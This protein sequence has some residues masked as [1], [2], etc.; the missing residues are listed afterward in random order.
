VRAWLFG[1]QEYE[2]SALRWL[3]IP[4][5]R[6]GLLM[7]VTPLALNGHGGGWFSW[8]GAA[9]CVVGLSADAINL[10]LLRR[11]RRATPAG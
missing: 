10:V 7:L 3:A 6:I 2:H 11:R 8:L 5:W 4:L 9:L 1:R